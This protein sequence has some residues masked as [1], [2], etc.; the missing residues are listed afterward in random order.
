MVTPATLIAQV[1]APPAEPLHKDLPSL[2]PA[3]PE[4]GPQRPS[5]AMATPS[6][7]N[8]PPRGVTGYTKLSAEKQREADALIARFSQIAGIPFSP[9]AVDL[10]TNINMVFSALLKAGKA[11]MAAEFMR[12]IVPII[13][14]P[15]EHRVQP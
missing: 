4:P 13:L 15:I 5:D 8:E 3:V 10:N 12:A 1:P 6:P 9:G 7:P 14:P 11:D 2:V